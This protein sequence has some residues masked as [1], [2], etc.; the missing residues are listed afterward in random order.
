[1]G[2]SNTSYFPNTVIFHFHDGESQLP[3]PPYDRFSCISQFQFGESSWWLT[4][5]SEKYATVKLDHETPKR[6]KH[7]KRFETTT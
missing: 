1:M 2:P 7:K 3:F 4:Q 5:P 6:G